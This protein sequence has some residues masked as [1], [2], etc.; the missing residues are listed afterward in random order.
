VRTP[1][2]GL[3]RT[4]LDAEQAGLCGMSIA[5]TARE[6]PER[7]AIASRHGDRS[8]DFLNRRV[9]ALVR[10][11]RARGVG[12][13]D[14][15]A[16]LCGNR[17]EFAVAAFAALRAGWR[18]TPIHTELRSAEL[19]YIIDDC[20]A[21]ALIADGRFAEAAAEAVRCVP[22]ASIRLGVG[23][24]IH[25][26]EPWDDVLAAE[27]ED[28]IDDPVLGSQM[29]YTSGTTGQPKGVHR[30]PEAAI[31]Q[32]GLVEFIRS[33]EHRP[34][35]D[36]HLCTGPLYH[37]APFVFSLSMPLNL[38]CSIVLMDQWD[39]A[40][41]L[42]LIDAY[43][44]THTHMVP[45]MFRRLLELPEDERAGR[46]VSSLRV[47]LHGSTPCPV[48]VK[49]RMIDWFGPV[50]YEYYAA[51]EGWGCGIDSASWLEH[52]GSVGHP[53]AGHVEIR[54]FEGKVLPAG[55]EGVIYLRTPPGADF[56]YF[57]DD[58]KTRATHSG[59]FFTLG[60]IGYLDADG[61]LHVRDRSADVINAGGVNV[62]PAEVDAVLV[63]HEAVADAATVGVHDDETG[64][65]VV[66]VVELAEGW[67]ESARLE[68]DLVGFCRRQLAT[69]K[70]P[71]SVV[72]AQGLPRMQ[73]G[74][75]YRRLV[76]DLYR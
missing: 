36:L 68:S 25:G 61:W 66:A 9:N 73:N 70:C 55:R 57:R 31:H 42:T 28:D 22:R 2:D 50:L 44:I 29:P 4:T 34:G 60:D 21:Q 7:L 54:D 27:R 11:L 47:V 53:E 59:G 35:V 17:A 38:G 5:V 33:L 71:R 26:F 39:A 63:A 12:T 24:P 48:D 37:T 13:G 69:Y 75:I 72:F 40:R 20:E 46:R 15:V 30:A 67:L 64:E 14:G 49:Q 43:R 65:A 74:K 3:R 58:A 6:H 62:Y 45:V 32:P 56:R 10:A 1:D 41:A 16:L 23:D 8:Y 76:R 52:P 51:T 18:L 19:R